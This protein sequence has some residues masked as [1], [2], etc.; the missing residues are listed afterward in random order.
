M[1]SK[2]IINILIIGILLSKTLIFI[3]I[4]LFVKKN[5]ELKTEKIKLEKANSELII[6]AVDIRSYVGELKAAESF[7]TKVLSIASHDLRAPFASVESLLKLDGLSLMD[8]GKLESIFEILRQ[9]VAKSRG[10]LDEVLLW[11]ESQLRDS[12]ANKAVLNLNEEIEKLMDQFS[13]DINKMGKKVFNNIDKNLYININRPIFTFVIRNVISNASKFGQSDGVIS[14]DTVKKESG[15][16][17][18]IILN[19]GEQ[20][21]EHI[22]ESLNYGKSWERMKTAESNGTGLGI[23]LCQD[24]FKRINGILSFENRIGVGVAVTIMFPQDS[25]YHDSYLI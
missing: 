12:I 8:K 21:S 10:M 6:Q 5:R 24:L 22:I 15:E 19:E 13:C 18:V 2:T 23:S 1:D 11:T 7:K 20:L 14:I 16:C 9:E 17:G 25:C 3:L 4:Y